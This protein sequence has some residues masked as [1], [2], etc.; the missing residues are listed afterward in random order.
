MTNIQTSHIE[1]AGKAKHLG[2]L[3]NI[4]RRLFRYSPI[5]QITVDQ[6]CLPGTVFKR[7]VLHKYFTDLFI[8]LLESFY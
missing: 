7:S 1:A 8:Y 2:I 5:R 4:L 6:L 3:V